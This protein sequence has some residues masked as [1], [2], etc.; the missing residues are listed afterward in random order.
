MLIGWA[1]GWRASFLTPGVLSTVGLGATIGLILGSIQSL[2]LHG[3]LKGPGWWVLA[4]V[5]GWAAGFSVGVWLGQQLGLTEA[6][7]GFVIGLVTGAF[8][9]VSQWIVLRRQV[10]DAGWWIPACIFAWAASLL[11]YQPGVTWLGVLYGTLSGIVTG[12]VLLW[13]L[14]R[15]VPDAPP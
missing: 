3:Q 6:T 8:L 10:P 12:T 7:F 14:Y 15:P 4:N 2:V 13:L 5:I 9:G 11:Y 1:V